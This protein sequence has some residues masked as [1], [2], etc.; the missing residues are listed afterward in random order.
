MALLMASSFLL[1]KHQ[2]TLVDVYCVTRN[3]F[4]TGGTGQAIPIANLTVF[5][6][7]E[8]ILYYHSRKDQNSK[9]GAL[10]SYFLDIES[11]GAAF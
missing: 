3:Y 1:L 4:F 7:S 10:R 2:E 9:C 11:E 6:E 8:E 5:P